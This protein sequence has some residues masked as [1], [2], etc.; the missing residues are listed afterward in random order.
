M[1]RHINRAKLMKRLGC[2]RAGHAR[3]QARVPGTLF[4]QNHD[5]TPTHGG[6]TLAIT[7]DCPTESRVAHVQPL[8]D[9]GPM[10]YCEPVPSGIQRQGRCPNALRLPCLL[11]SR[12]PAWTRTASAQFRSDLEGQ[13]CRLYYVNHNRRWHLYDGVEPSRGLASLLADVDR[14]PTDIFFGQHVILGPVAPKTCL[15]HRWPSSP[16]LNETCGE[17]GF[18]RP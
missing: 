12:T 13:V 14:D 10:Q 7:Q 6:D 5:V 8:P 4:E 2:A 15:H 16:Y 9:E 17:P 18:Y 11:V 1:E 3:L